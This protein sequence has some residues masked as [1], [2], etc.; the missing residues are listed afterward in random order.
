MRPNRHLQKPPRSAD[1]V[2]DNMFSRRVGP[3]VLRRRLN[4][5]V[6]ENR[7]RRCGRDMLW[8]TVPSTGSSNREGRPDRR[9]WTAVYVRRTFSDSGEAATTI[10]CKFTPLA[11]TDRTRPVRAFLHQELISL[12][13]S[14]CCSFNCCCWGD[15]LK[16]AKG[17]IVSNRIGMKYYSAAGPA[18]ANWRPCSNCAWVRWKSTSHLP[19][20]YCKKY[21][22]IC[23]RNEAP[24]SDFGAWIEA[25]KVPRGW[26]SLGGVSTCWAHVRILVSHST[27]Q[28]TLI[29]VG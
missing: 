25:P 16:K 12:Y 3:T 17:S 15:L 2:F 13:S 8:Q 23:A 20:V 18:L 21:R 14:C 9:R 27:V 28:C 7:H 19:L 6:S 1:R 11:G 10:N 26:G 22:W 4:K 24:S 5:S 29:S